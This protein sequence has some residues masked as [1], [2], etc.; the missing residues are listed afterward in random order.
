MKDVTELL[1]ASLAFL[2]GAAAFAVGGQVIREAWRGVFK[3]A[4]RTAPGQAIDPRRRVQERSG[5]G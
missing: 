1:L 2:L 4:R 3:S 5:K